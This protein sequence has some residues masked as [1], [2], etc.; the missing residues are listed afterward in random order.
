MW[1]IWLHIHCVCVHMC[2]WLLQSLCNL[3]C[4]FKDRVSHWTWKSPIPLGWLTSKSPQLLLCWDYKH[5]PLYPSFYEDAGQGTQVPMFEQQ[6]LYCTAPLSQV[7]SLKHFSCWNQYTWT[8]LGNHLTELIRTTDPF[9]QTL[10]RSGRKK[11][12]AV[13]ERHQELETWH[14]FTVTF[15]VIQTQILS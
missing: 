7:P 13:C 9:G 5:A 2:G 11:D 10:V 6:A 8:C 1:Y 12:W 4:F 14:F 15:W 3:G